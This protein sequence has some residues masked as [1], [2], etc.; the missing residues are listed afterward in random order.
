MPWG[1]TRPVK[2]SAPS[3]V[4]L[5]PLGNL[6]GT[7]R[8]P[9]VIPTSSHLPQHLGGGWRRETEAGTPPRPGATP[10]DSGDTAVTLQAPLAASTTKSWPSQPP[11]IQLHGK[12]CKMTESPLIPAV[13]N[14]FGIQLMSSPLQLSSLHQL[15]KQACKP[16][17]VC[18]STR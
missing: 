4:P 8:E 18:T 1:L 10:R 5:W 2:L 13:I 11:Q 16:G 7:T 3:P 6:A 15:G 14:P 17:W 9:G 12:T